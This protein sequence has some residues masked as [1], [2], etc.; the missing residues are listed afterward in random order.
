MPRSRCSIT[1]MSGPMKQEWSAGCRLAKVGFLD[2]M[3]ANS[4]RTKVFFFELLHE[5]HR[6]PS[7]IARKSKK[8]KWGFDLI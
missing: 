2:L 1:A 6:K 7:G 4:Q 5:N 8:N 3:Y